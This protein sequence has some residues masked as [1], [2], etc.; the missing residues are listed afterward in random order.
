MV[1]VLKGS[2]MRVAD[3]NNKKGQ[4]KVDLWCQE[5][6]GNERHEIAVTSNHI[7]CMILFLF[8]V[9]RS[10]YMFDSRRQESDFLKHH[11]RAARK[12]GGR[13]LQV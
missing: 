1:Q 10:T 5:A 6:K 4:S 3:R 11:S 12:L 2:S 8:F 13:W 7:G 9:S